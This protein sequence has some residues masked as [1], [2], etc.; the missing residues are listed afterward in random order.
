MDLKFHSRPFSFRLNR[1]LNTS[2]GSLEIRNGWLLHLEDQSG[3]VGWGEASPYEDEEMKEIEDF[4]VG[5][6]PIVSRNELEDRMRLGP[7]ALA[8]GI[9]SALAE[10]DGV[11]GSRS[12]RNWL[13]PPSS[14]IL[15]PAGKD[16]LEALDVALE[17]CLNASQPL[18]FKWK[19]AVRPYLEEMD[20]LNKL[21]QRLPNSSRLRLD[22]NGGWDRPTAAMWVNRLVNVQRLEWLE[23]PLPAEDIEGLRDLGNQ[24]PVALDESLVWDNSLR[25]SWPGWQVRRPVLEGDPRMLLAEFEEGISQRMIS[26]AFETGIGRRWVHHMAAL[27][28]EGSTPTAPGLAMEWFPKGSLFSTDPNLVWNAAG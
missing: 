19:V 6:G 27:Q 11:V 4:L 13:E 23:Q 25:E 2:K 8:F 1:P 17:L 5:R 22:A 10:L 21:M 28:Q 16:A 14:A 20:L 18:T 26:T 12:N 7:G 15:L 9:G 3:G 24:L